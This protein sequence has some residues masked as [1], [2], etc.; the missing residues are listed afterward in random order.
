MAE[1]TVTPERRQKLGTVR[2]AND[3][4]AWISAL[5]ALEVKGVRA[6]YRPGNDNTD[7]MLRPARAHRGVR[8]EK[9]VE[10]GLSMSVWI[11]VDAGVHV[12]SVGADVQKRIVQT[13]DRMLGLSVHGVN[14][15]VAEVVFA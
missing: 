4:V 1:A 11:A 15:F 8:V 3:V 12:P 10:T 5:A 7:R 6:L 14:V 9:D 2:V 13:I